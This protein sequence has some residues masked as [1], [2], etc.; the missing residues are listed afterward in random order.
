M[1]LLAEVCSRTSQFIC[2]FSC[3]IRKVNY[4]QRPVVDYFPLTA[5][6]KKSKGKKKK[7]SHLLFELRKEGSGVACGSVPVISTL[8]MIPSVI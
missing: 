4:N 2:S 1:V 7:N 8:E 6:K 5:K 3:N